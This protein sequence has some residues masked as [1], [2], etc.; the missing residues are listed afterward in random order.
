MMTQ[1]LTLGKK[2][3]IV[4]ATP[5]RLADHLANTKGFNLKKLKFLVSIVHCNLNSYYR[6]III[7]NY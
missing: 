7:V 5:G 4:I 1:A 2:P 6:K 3:H